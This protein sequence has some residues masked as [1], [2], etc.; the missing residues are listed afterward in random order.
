[1]K[2][3]LLAIAVFS[4]IV[5]VARSQETDSW[6]ESGSYTKWMRYSYEIDSNYKYVKTLPTLE[7]FPE[8][9]KL[10]IDPRFKGKPGVAGDRVI[11]VSQLRTISRCK[12]DQLLYA[13]SDVEGEHRS[14]IAKWK[15]WWDVYGKRY[16]EEYRKEGKRYPDAWK[17]I[18]GAK[19]LPCPSYPLLLPDSWS[20][21]LKFR[22]GDY[23]GIVVEEIELHASPQAC[24]LKRRY[25]IGHG[26]PGG[27]DWI[28][29]EWNDLTYAETQEFLATLTYAVDNPWLF[30]G[31]QFANVDTDSRLRIGSVRGRP[32]KWSNYYPGVEW[33]GI[34]DRKGNVIMNDDPWSWHTND[35]DGFGKTMFD[36]TI[37]IAF[38]VFRDAFP[39]PTYRPKESRWTTS[40]KG[41]PSD[42]PK[43]RASSIDNGKST[44]VPRDFY[45]YRKG[46][47]QLRQTLVLLTSYILTAYTATRQFP[48]M[49]QN[50]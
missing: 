10:A 22:S 32:N 28:N 25:R 4:Y 46:G 16:A 17:K 47:P 48:T 37:G 35:F 45:R 15:Q 3:I 11:I 30:L 29:E 23:G 39:D 5:G 31:D 40:N 12:F 9:L 21:K 13:D 26:W 20:T 34:L 44:A 7:R 18:P 49:H 50:L 36:D 41:E 2:T 27:T 8:L 33:S 24:K 43:D 42:A 1:M 6:G 19:N 38:R 14:A